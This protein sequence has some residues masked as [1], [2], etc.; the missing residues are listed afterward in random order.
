MRVAV[1]GASGTLGGAIYQQLVASGHKVVAVGRTPVG[2]GFIKADLGD[3]A[4]VAKATQGIDWLIHA[5][6]KVGDQNGDQSNVE[7]AAAIGAGASDCRII[8]LS[9]VAVY[10]YTPNR[11]VTEADI[12]QPASAYGLSKL[13]AE[14]AL[15]ERAASVCHLR[16]GNV[17]SS[18]S[19]LQE[20]SGSS[21]S[22]VRLLRANEVL[23]AVLDTD[24]AELVGYLIDMS[25]DLV[26]RV[27]V[28]RPDLGHRAIRSLAGPVGPF[29]IPDRFVPAR[30]S[31]LVRGLRG[32]PSLPNKIFTSSVLDRIG[33][34][35]RP[36]EVA[37]P[38]LWDQ[39]AHA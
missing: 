7:M 15:D 22:L 28:V 17:C 29:G 2:A 5:A 26:S 4:H 36:L 11:I 34:S 21:R 30:A 38:Q 32:V 23:N 39:I 6:G 25:G 19:T 24:V 35:Y 12:C 16:I 1:T 20:L 9:S 33:F 13:A 27:N 14:A 18:A 31:H 10:G 8:N 3:P 37:A